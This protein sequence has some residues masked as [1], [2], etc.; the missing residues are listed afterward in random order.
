MTTKIFKLTIILL[1]INCLYS[2]GQL[3]YYYNGANYEL[4]QKKRTLYS[5]VSFNDRHSSSRN[6]SISSS[7]SRLKSAELMG[8]YLSFID[9]YPLEQQDSEIFTLF[10]KY[11][12]KGFKANISDIESR[13]LG[14]SDKVLIEFSCPISKYHI[15]ELNPSSFPTAAELS[16]QHYV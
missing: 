11:Y 1:M 16:R 7:Q 9:A 8:L 15:S 2:Y 14:S 10:V 5:L 3:S 13:R 12:G 6:M 4:T